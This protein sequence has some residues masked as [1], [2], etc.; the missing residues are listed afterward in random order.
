MKGVL[1]KRDTYNQKVTYCSSGDELLRFW[2]SKV[3]VE[4]LRLDNA[5]ELRTMTFRQQSSNCGVKT[6]GMS[7]ESR[8][9]DIELDDAERVEF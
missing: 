5:G 1:S 9:L 2:G 3:G 8:R 7:G 4:R 6:H